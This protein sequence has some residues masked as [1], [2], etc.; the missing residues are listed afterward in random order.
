MPLALGPQWIDPDYLISTFGLIGVFV[1]GT[2]WAVDVTVL[3][4]FLGQVDVVKNNIEFILVAIV[5]VSVV[6]L[7]VE[8]LRA[9]YGNRNI[10]SGQC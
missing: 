6:P 7:A 4:Y 5:V 10:R 1:L 3:D 2:L 9:R 8:Y